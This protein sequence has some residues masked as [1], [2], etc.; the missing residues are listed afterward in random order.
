MVRVPIWDLSLSPS[1]WRINSGTPKHVSKLYGDQR[2]YRRA[3]REH[4]YN[5]YARVLCRISCRS[6]YRPR[7]ISRS[8]RTGEVIGWRRIRKASSVAYSA[9]R[10]MRFASHCF[11]SVVTAPAFACSQ[12]NEPGVGAPILLI[13]DRP[14]R[15]DDACQ[16]RTRAATSAS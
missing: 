12:L 8:P 14:V 15:I 16:A 11:K 13:S 2:M 9:P 6:R 1:I 3:R 5:R 10:K 4:R 7:T